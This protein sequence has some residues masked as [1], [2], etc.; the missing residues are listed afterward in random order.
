MIFVEY[1]VWTEDATEKG[2]RIDLLIQEVNN[3]RAIIIENKINHHLNNDLQDYWDSVKCENSNKIGIVLT[4]KMEVVDNHN[5][6]N[7]THKEF[8]KQIEFNFGNYILNSDD[9][10]LLFFKDF[11]ENIKNLTSSMQNEKETTEFF[12]K[13]MNKI[14][15]LYDLREKYRVY[16]LDSIKNASKE[17]GL[18]LENT[19]PKYYR[20]II[21]HTNPYL[22]YWITF[23]FSNA[24]ECLTIYLELYDVTKKDAPHLINNN[25]LLKTASENGIDFEIFD[26]DK[27]GIAFAVGKY[28]LD[29]A[30]VVNLSES[31]V[32]IINKDWKDLTNKVVSEIKNNEE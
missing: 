21:V 13:N 8:I 23:S 16:F 20:C 14:E 12:F 22:R 31:I 27:N 29:E 5:F 2:G 28:Y 15:E 11:C 9:R 26:E 19:N 1:D 32:E 4:K 18:S 3:S 6:I 17:L 7:I 24:S 10:H 25:V 30:K